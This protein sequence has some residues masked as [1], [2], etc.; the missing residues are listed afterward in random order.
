MIKDYIKSNIYVVDD[1]NPTYIAKA[2]GK[3]VYTTKTSGGIGCLWRCDIV[4]GQLNWIAI[5]NIAVLTTDTITSIE[6]AYQG[7]LGIDVSNKTLYFWSGSESGWLSISS[8]S[9]EDDD[10]KASVKI[11]QDLPEDL[12][13]YKEGSLFIKQILS[14]DKS[15]V[16]AGILYYLAILGETKTWVKLSEYDTITPSEDY[17]GLKADIAITD[18]AMGILKKLLEKELFSKLSGTRSVSISSITPSKAEFGSTVN[19][20]LTATSSRR[21]FSPVYLPT[22]EKDPSKTSDYYEGNLIEYKF[23]DN[24]QKPPVSTGTSNV[25]T[26]E[27]HIVK[28]TN[29]WAV[30][31]KFDEGPIIYSSQGNI[32]NAGNLTQCSGVTTRSDF[33]SLIV[34]YPVYGTTETSLELTF[35]QLDDSLSNDFDVNFPVEVL[36][37]DSGKIKRLAFLVPTVLSP[38]GDNL[39]IEMYDAVSKTY[40]DDSANWKQIVLETVDAIDTNKN[41]IYWDAEKKKG[42]INVLASSTDSDS[43]LT[44][45]VNGHFPASIEQSFKYV[46]HTGAQYTGSF[47]LRITK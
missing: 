45:E 47:K 10:S 26:I 22:G 23:K 39:K 21:T 41:C 1:T 19:I 43:V 15:K 20:T 2:K 3:L 30:T 16:D 35:K 32:G 12:S 31:A 6:G 46:V 36:D 5:T 29:T 11:G 8:N 9:E 44:K 24:S 7:Q 38:E 27:N 40:I 4:D 33:K 34:T 25:Y 17:G 37:A 28:A 18:T 13:D 42:K 14:K